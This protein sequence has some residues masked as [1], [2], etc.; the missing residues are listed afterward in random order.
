MNNKGYSF[1]IVDADISVV[2]PSRCPAIQGQ[3]RTQCFDNE[4]AKGVLTR[5]QLAEGLW[6]RKWCLTAEKKIEVRRA[7]SDGEKKFGLLYF[8]QPDIFNVRAGSKK[9]KLGSANNIV[10][11]NSDTTVDFTVLPRYPFYILDIVFTHE[12]I[13][14]QFADREDLLSLYSRQLFG[15][16]ASKGLL[17]GCTPEDYR[18]L[19]DLENTDV[20]EA[21]TLNI[22]SM[23]YA[24]LQLFFQ[25]LGVP[26]VLSPCSIQ[27]AKVAR[28]ARMCATGL[29]GQFNLARMAGEVNM[30]VSSL[31]RQFRIVF[32]KSIHEFRLQKKME[33]ARELLIASRCSMKELAGMFGYKNQSHFIEVFSRYHGCTPGSLRNWK[34]RLN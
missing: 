7:C 23:I 20:S 8:S 4:L 10:G 14:G 18:L 32:D 34:V 9:L 21:D 17:Q 28:V 13:S 29:S 1:E 27:Y 5:V 26:A 30:S 19:F 3:V 16:T 12:W 33:V 6:I 2:S 11:Y 31:L 24:L 22:R 15:S 25:R